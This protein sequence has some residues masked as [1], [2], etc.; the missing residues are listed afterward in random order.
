[1]ALQYYDLVLGG[2]FVSVL[3]GAL[4]GAF[5]AVSGLV[6]I[7]TACA[8]AAGLI[9]HA[10][11]VGPVDGVEDLSKEVEQIGPIELAE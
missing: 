6:A 9:G 4:V 2:I 7:V 10:I 11:F 8:V 3:S 5:T 1:M